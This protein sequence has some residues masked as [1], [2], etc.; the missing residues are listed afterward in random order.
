MKLGFIRKFP[1]FA[2]VAGV[3]VGSTALFALWWF[4]RKVSRPEIARV[5]VKEAP[6]PILTE[7]LAARLGQLAVIDNDLYDVTSGEL[8][9][10]GWLKTEMPA[11]LELEKGGKTLLG[12]YERD[13][14][15]FSWDGSVLA[16]LQMRQ[17]LVLSADLKSLI[18]VKDQNIWLGEIDWQAL[19]V[20]R[21][22]QVT[23]INQFMEQFFSQNILLLTER[24]LVVR[25]LNA[26][27]RVDLVSGEVHPIRIAESRFGKQRSPDFRSVVGAEAGQLF[28][29]D[30]DSGENKT[31]PFKGRA[32]QD[33]LWLTK[34]RCAV[35][36]GGDTVYV[37]D[38]GAHSLEEAVKL[39]VGCREL[40]LPSADGRLAFGAAMQGG[41]LIDFQKRQAEPVR[42]GNG[43]L[44]G[45]RDHFLVSREVPDSTWR[46]TWLKGVGE[47][48]RRVMDEP[49]VVGKGGGVVLPLKSGLL[50]LYTKQGW[51]SMGVDGG[52]VSPMPKL[53]MQFR[54]AIAIDPAGS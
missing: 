16:R 52:G 18:Y 6:R 2:L 25:N 38:R 4:T 14:V 15:R 53:P 48:E 10:K 11:V 43:L 32:V 33:Y 17:P 51:R 37:Y 27:L 5:A 31:L 28:C 20:G 46:G 21:E 12:R 13:L 9:A 44:W 47:E 36:S 26:T 39:P 29:F 42:S 22:R 23:S 30:V 40:I 45:S 34:E 1:K 8:L 41:V 49:Y 50:L 19:K 35:L 24:T 54:Q 7:Q 3:L